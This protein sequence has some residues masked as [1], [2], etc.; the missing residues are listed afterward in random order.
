[1]INP[2]KRTRLDDETNA[3]G[4]PQKAQIVS[5]KPENPHNKRKTTIS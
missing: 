1:M 3:I 4:K 2:T 5:Q